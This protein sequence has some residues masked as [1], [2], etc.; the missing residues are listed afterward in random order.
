MSFERPTTSSRHSA[1]LQ[2][3]LQTWLAE[4][5]DSPQILSADRPPTNGMSSETLLFDVAFQRDGQRVVESCV[6]RIP[7]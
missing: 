3:A 1:D 2:V 6:A 7:P 5:V 4:R